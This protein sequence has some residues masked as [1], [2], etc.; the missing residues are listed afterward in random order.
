MPIY[1]YKCSSCGHTQ[2]VLQKFSAA[3]LADCPACGK[4]TYSKQITAPQ[5]QLKGSG[6]Y[7]TDFRGGG[8][9]GKENAD[10]KTEPSKADTKTE[11]AAE[12]KG[13]SKSNGA[14]EAAPPASAPSTPAAV[15][16][17][18]KPAAAKE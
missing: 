17:P 16:A 11:T 18:A 3:P 8:S 4:A 5:F 15:P 12:T 6:W 10:G 1:A 13:D 2:D 9:G 14:K 7:V